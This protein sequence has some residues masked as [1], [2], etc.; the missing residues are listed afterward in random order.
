MSRRMTTIDWGRAASALAGVEAVIFDLDGVT[1]DTASVHEAAWK[2]VFD[3]Y[4]RARAEREGET[5]ES[6]TG[7]DYRRYVDGMPRYDGVHN[8]LASRKITLPAGEPDD[9]PERE[10]VCGIGNRKNLSFLAV[11]NEQGAEAFPSSVE[12]LHELRDRGV[13]RAIISASRN[14]REVLD[15]A[16]I[17]EL[18]DARVDGIEAESLGLAGKPD[19]AVFEEAAR[20]LGIEPGHAAVIED[21]V[22]GV[23]AGSKGGFSPVIGVARQDNASELLD[24]GADLVVTDLGELC[25][26]Q[27]GERAD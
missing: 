7:V 4:L 26:R 8:F 11:L 5:A 14:C 24:A 21:A 13:P 17:A 15:S 18:F 16:G 22:A 25:D 2:R 20:R 19:P 23:E 6:F 3:A 1:T 27:G 12:L 9:P 10:T